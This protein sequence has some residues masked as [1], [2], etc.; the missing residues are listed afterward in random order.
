M[1]VTS[2][3]L[4]GNFAAIWR[5]NQRD[6]LR[7]AIRLLRLELHKSQV[8]R[9]V[10]RAYNRLG[11]DFEIVTTRF[12]AA[13]YD[14]LHFVAASLRVSVSWLVYRMIL[15]WQKK[16][17][18]YQPNQFVTN[19]ELNLCIWNRNAGVCTEFLLFWPKQVQGIPIPPPAVP[20]SSARLTISL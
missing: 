18:R 9:G 2:V 6:V 1:L 5:A 19:Y 3:S 4:P 20:S 11:G 13:E 12:S 14:A 8:Q 10:K 15:L 17:R 7:M 16:S